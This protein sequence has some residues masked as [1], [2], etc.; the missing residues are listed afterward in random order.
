[1]RYTHRL[2]VFLILMVWS[3][4]AQTPALT[5]DRPGIGVGSGVV[6]RATLQFEGGFAYER[7]PHFNGYSFGQ[8]LVRYGLTPL[9]E[10]RMGFPSYR[11]EHYRRNVEQTG[12]EDPLVGFKVA[13]RGSA[14][15][16]VPS[17]AILFELRLPVG[18]R[19]FQAPST[20]PIATLALDWPLFPQLSLSSNG[21][22]MSYWIAGRRTDEGLLTVTLNV[23]LSEV[24]P[25]TVYFGYAQR[26]I[27][28]Q[29]QHY[30][31]SGLA[32][33]LTPD[34]QFDINSGI[35]LHQQGHYFIGA[36]LV[37]RFWF[38]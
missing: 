6:P 13:L 10:L 1:M 29:N 26:F 27:P 28:G 36:G 35:G 18:N 22:V 11:I 23:T 37:R 32:L 15:L 8:T 38:R 5:T 34:L 9:V 2:F 3:A 19:D 4:Y 33:L 31:E 12:F 24:L 17:M 14:N 30:L 21:T 16:R 7:A 25:S 20:Q